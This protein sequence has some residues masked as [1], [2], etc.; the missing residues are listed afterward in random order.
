MQVSVDK[1]HDLALL[2]GLSSCFERCLQNDRFPQQ[3]LMYLLLNH[4]QTVEKKQY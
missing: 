2:Y 1:I 4:G 3:N